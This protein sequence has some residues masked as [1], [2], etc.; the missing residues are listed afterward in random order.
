MRVE[1]DIENLDPQPV[2]LA[3][4]DRVLRHAAQRIS[5]DTNLIDR[6]VIASPDRFGTAVASIR[7]G[8]T[9]TNTETTVAA[10]KTFS[11][12]AVSDIVFQCSLFGALTGVLGDP[13]TS[14]D[15]GV[16]QQQAIYVICHEFGHALDHSLRNDVATVPDPRGRPF[17]IKETADY[18]GDIVLTEYAACRNSASVMTDSLFDHEMREAGSRMAACGRQVNYYLDNAG[19]LTPRALAHF[20]CQGAWLYMTELAK[21]Y[22]Y[23]AATDAR[24]AMARQLEGE[25][26]AGAP[27]GD[28]LDRI[29]AAYPAWNGEYLIAELTGV[30]HTYTSLSNVRFIHQDGGPDVIEDMGKEN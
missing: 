29:G 20:V 21:L 3:F 4:F 23:G 14:S 8:A 30:W 11:R 15:W 5:L 24:K 9:H 22:G 16:D 27:L 6:I 1:C 26:V 25:M 10:A 18:Y 28:A 19:V 13:P 7:P 2:L 12:R 17:T